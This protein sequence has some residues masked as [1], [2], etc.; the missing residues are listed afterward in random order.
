MK[1]NKDILIDKFKSIKEQGPVP[2]RRSSDTGIGKTFEDYCNIKENNSQGPDF[3]EFEIKSHREESSSYVTLFTK[4]P[5]FPLN[6]NKYLKDK[7][8]SP[9][10]DKPDLKRLHTSLFANTWNTY[11]NKFAFKLENDRFTE[12]L[13]IKVKD[14]KTNE[15]LDCHV[16]YTYDDI[17]KRLIDKIP[18]LFYVSARSTKDKATGNELFEYDQAEIYYTPSIEHFFLLLSEGKIMFDIRIG[19]YKS[20]KNKG[21]PHDH[22]SGFR[23]RKQNIKYLFCEH[24]I[25][26]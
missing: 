15:I 18:N 21:K 25:I 22:G 7:F 5:S 20:G 1:T 2:S 14:L 12:C 8:G 11:E 17:K 26:K 6:A 10:P 16:G 19:S 13:Y 23:I 4:S 9:Y 3:H 24:E